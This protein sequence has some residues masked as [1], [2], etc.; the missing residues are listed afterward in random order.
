MKLSDEAKKSILEGFIDI[1]T[2]ISSLEYQKRVWVNGNGPEVDDFDDTV[3]DFFGE[4]D[5]ILE[6]YKDFGIRKDQF[7]SLIK[8]RDAF[9][10][11]SHKNDWPNEFIDSPE[12][13]TITKMAQDIL[14]LFNYKRVRR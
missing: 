11:F 9:S 7:E 3:N 10:A 8:F 12:W 2:R 5:S 1:F 13:K 6:N 4:C 14:A